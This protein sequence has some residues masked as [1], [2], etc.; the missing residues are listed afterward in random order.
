MSEYDK[1]VKEAEK[2]DEDWTKPR[3]SLSAE[4][5]VNLKWGKEVSMPHNWS[6]S[7]HFVCSVKL[8]ALGRWIVFLFSQADPTTAI[9]KQSSCDGL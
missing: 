2:S 3:R 8:H 4:Q 6:I 5:T 9:L 1:E 7:V